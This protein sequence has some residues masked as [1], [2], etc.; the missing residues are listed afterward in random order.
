MSL[1]AL[2]KK[3]FNELRA[4]VFPQ[5]GPHS[6]NAQVLPTADVHLKPA[7]SAAIDANSH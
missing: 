4:N 7:D 1:K 2:P 5:L 6:G 3:L